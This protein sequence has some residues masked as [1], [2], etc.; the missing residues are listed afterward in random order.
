MNLGVKQPLGDFTYDLYTD[1]GTVMVGEKNLG[2]SYHSHNQKRDKQ[3]EIN[4]ESGNI[5]IQAPTK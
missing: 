5:E 3:C 2:E 1:Y 4:C